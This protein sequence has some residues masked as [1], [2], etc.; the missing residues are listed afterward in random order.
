MATILAL[1]SAL[2]QLL[3][4]GMDYI[5]SNKDRLLGWMQATQKQ[6]EEGEKLDAEISEIARN[7]PSPEEV[8]KRLR[9][10]D[11]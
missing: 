8:R 6:A 1:L 3:V 9:D 7:K 11:I 5:Q 10:G 2:A 4:K